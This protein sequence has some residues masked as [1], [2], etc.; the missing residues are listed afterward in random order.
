MIMVGRAAEVAPIVEGGA[1]VD[2][3]WDFIVRSIGTGSC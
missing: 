3:L 1:D 2:E